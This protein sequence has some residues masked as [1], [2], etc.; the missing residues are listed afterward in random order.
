MDRIPAF[1]RLAALYEEHGYALYLIGGTSRDL[2][3]GLHPDDLDACTDA[4]VEEAVAFLPSDIDLSFER[5]GRVKMSK[6]FGKMEIT[7]LRE[8]GPYLDHRHP[9]YLKF[10]K[11]LK[12]DSFRRDFTINAIYLDKNYTPIDFHDGLGDLERRIIRTIGDPYVRFKEDPLRIPRAERL[13]ARLGFAIEQKTMEALK[14][15]YPLLAEL[16]PAKLLEE[17]RKG[18]TWPKSIKR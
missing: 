18:W 2:L 13:A 16:N 3:L 12:T 14:A 4:R 10:V 15:C 5:F 9:S 11:D 6:A 1:D 7:T 8:E 17:E